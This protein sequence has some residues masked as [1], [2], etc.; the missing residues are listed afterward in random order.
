MVRIK[1]K[2]DRRGIPVFLASI[3]DKEKDEYTFIKRALIESKEVKG[4]YK[5]QVPLKYLLPIFKNIDENIVVIDKC[6][7][8]SYFEFADEEEGKFFY[9]CEA[10]A[11]YM[12]QWREQSCP[13]IYKIKIDAENNKIEKIM[14]FKKIDVRSK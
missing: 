14:A 10:S 11:K 6:S 9:A 8:D 2:K 13:Y 7:I 12:K 4:R 5:Y 1:I 3:S